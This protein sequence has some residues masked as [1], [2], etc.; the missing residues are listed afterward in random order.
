MTL[1][2]EVLAEMRRLVLV[3]GWRLNAVAREFEA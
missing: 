2:A 3:E 1:P